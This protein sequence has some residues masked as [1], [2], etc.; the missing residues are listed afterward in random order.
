MSD[1]LKGLDEDSEFTFQFLECFRERSIVL[2]IPPNCESQGWD[3]KA[4]KY[5]YKVYCY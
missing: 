5:P 3:I 4:F 2:D 1:K